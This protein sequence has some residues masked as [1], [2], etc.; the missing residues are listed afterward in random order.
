MGELA[1]RRA[2]RD[3]WISYGHL[4]AMGAGT[5]LLVGI[6]FGLGFTVGRGDGAAR[7]AATSTAMPTDDGALVQ[8]LARLDANSRPHGG[9]EALTF[10]EALTGQAAPTVPQTPDLPAGASSA[11]VPADPTAPLPQGDVIPGGKY[12][13]QVGVYSSV[14]QAGLL[15]N[16]LRAH[17]IDAWVRTERIDGHPRVQVDVGGYADEAA[18]TTALT[19]FGG[20]LPS[21]QVVALP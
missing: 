17:Q 9:V 10:P 21:A 2:A 18:A 11:T 8:L 5:V 12:T 7:A 19:G 15:R 1:S 13:I 4:W 16:D 14:E 3:L 20:E 6:S